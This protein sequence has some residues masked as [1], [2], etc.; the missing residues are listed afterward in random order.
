MASNDKQI[1]NPKKRLKD[2]ISN[3]DSV[4]RDYFEAIPEHLA[5]LQ[6]KN[7]FCKF[8]SDYDF[9]YFKITKSGITSLIDDY[10]LSDNLHLDKD[11]HQSLKLIQSALRLSEN[12]LSKDNEQLASQL[13]GRLMHDSDITSK[14][15]DESKQWCKKPWLRLLFPSMIQAGGPLIRTLEGHT[16]KTTSLAVTPDGTKLVST[17]DDMTIASWDVYS[18]KE[19]K[20]PYKDIGLVT[21]L[22]VTPD[23]TKLVSR[24]SEETIRVWDMYSGKEISRIKNTVPTIP[25]LVTADGTKLLSRS[26]N[27]TIRVW[28]MYSGK[29]ISRRPEEWKR[30]GL[31]TSLAVTP[32]ETKLV[33]G[34]DNGIIIVWD[35]M[36]SGKEIKRLHKYNEI[37]TSLAVTPDGTKLVSGSQNI[38]P[39]HQIASTKTIRIWD[40]NSGKEI[41]KMEGNFGTFI[42]LAVTPDGTK[43]ESRS[44]FDVVVVWDMNSG[45]EISKMEGN[46]GTF[47]SLAL[48]PDGTKM[49]AGAVQS[50]GHMMHADK[51][52]RPIVSD[53]QGAGAQKGIEIGQHATANHS[54]ND[55]SNLMS[56]MEPNIN[57]QTETAIMPRNVP[58]ATQISD[59]DGSLN[60]MENVSRGGDVLDSPQQQQEFLDVARSNVRN[61]ENLKPEIQNQV[62]QRIQEQ[63]NNHPASAGKIVDSARESRRYNINNGI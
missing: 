7:V 40:M 3:L 56:A 53:I 36:Y 55:I 48:T 44:W 10:E 16:G 63:M 43:I 60:N 15:L 38:T 59:F 28:D 18:G 39:Q 50:A 27:G 12:T 45:K 9:L 52:V 20:I 26:D 23:G 47:I 2:H 30:D 4:R 8:L 17:Y 34:Y 5:D 29:E 54:V 25:L 19:I 13:W 32:D 6:M 24:S 11:E 22:A 62:V 61:F 21:S 42:S 37:I 57:I 33:S 58:N 46:F 1:T 41:S 31:V 51:M 35:D 14:L 49:A